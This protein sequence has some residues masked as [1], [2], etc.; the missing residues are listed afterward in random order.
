[1]NHVSAKP[2]QEFGHDLYVVNLRHIGD[3]R[4]TFGQ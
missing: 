2:A 1:M 4:G 3:G